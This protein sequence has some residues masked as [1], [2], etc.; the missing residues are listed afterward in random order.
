MLR[1]YSSKRLQNYKTLS[2]MALKMTMIVCKAFAVY[3]ISTSRIVA[4]KRKNPSITSQVSL[5]A[6]KPD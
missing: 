4:L 5:K 6:F 1:G 2:D 3:G